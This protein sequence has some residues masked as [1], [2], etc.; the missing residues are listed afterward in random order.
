MGHD[1]DVDER[2]MAKAC[3]HNRL[4]VR[5]SYGVSDEPVRSV[6][7]IPY[8]YMADV[9]VICCLWNTDRKDKWKG[10]EVVPDSACARGGDLLGMELV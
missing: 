4:Y 2:R 7:S 9:D 5:I 10:T 3:I 6:R 1:Y 8:A